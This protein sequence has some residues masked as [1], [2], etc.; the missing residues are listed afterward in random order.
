MSFLA[1]NKKYY[2]PN[3]ATLVVAGDIDFATTKKMIQDY[4]G[5]IPR[6]ANVVRSFPT[7]TPITK[8]RAKAYDANIQ[9]PAVIGCL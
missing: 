3:N 5:P 8:K 2:V 6:G 4:F 9:I 1:F 7:E